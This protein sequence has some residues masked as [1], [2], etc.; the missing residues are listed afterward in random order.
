MAAR[1]TGMGV[2]GIALAALCSSSAARAQSGYTGPMVGCYGITCVPVISIGAYTV[3]GFA[4]PWALND[5]ILSNRSATGQFTANALATGF[6]SR[7][8]S[9]SAIP[10]NRLDG[11]D[12]A[13]GDEGDRNAQNHKG[14]R[15]DHGNGRDRSNASRFNPAT[16]VYTGLAAT[17]LV[18]F[19]NSSS[20]ASTMAVF[21]SSAATAAVTAPVMAHVDFAPATALV[22]TTG[23]VTTPEPMAQT[24]MATGLVV[25]GMLAFLRRRRGTND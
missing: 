14:D 15:D 23:L 20:G 22:A 24:L 21:E 3:P 9:S 7:A 13:R 8:V 6:P 1:W 25:L 2:T 11:D 12:D 4:V 19:L 5:P 10:S 17:A 18:S 16:V